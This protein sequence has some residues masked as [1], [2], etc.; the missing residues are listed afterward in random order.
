GR[1]SFVGAT[2]SCRQL[3]RAG[4]RVHAVPIANKVRAVVC[5]LHQRSKPVDEDDRSI[6]ALEA[7]LGHCFEAG[8]AEQAAVD[9]DDVGINVDGCWIPQRRLPQHLN[10]VP[11]IQQ[12]LVHVLAQTCIRQ[13]GNLDQ[14]WLVCCLQ[15][16]AQGSRCIQDI[17]VNSNTHW[18]NPLVQKSIELKKV[19]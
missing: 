19:Y 1:D 15:S 5:L 7:Q 17:V 12:S 11:V 4:Q 18:T 2:A 14:F 16:G 3:Q 6:D 8:Q 10:G 13:K 9:D